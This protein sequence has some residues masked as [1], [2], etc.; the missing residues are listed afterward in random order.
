VALLQ[1]GPTQNCWCMAESTLR[2]L[3]SY[4]EHLDGDIL[5]EDVGN[6]CGPIC[7][8]AHVAPAGESGSILEVAIVGKSFSRV[9]A[10]Y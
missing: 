3:F 2:F 7:P 8:Q 1:D 9:D 6:H 5:T 10:M 4:D